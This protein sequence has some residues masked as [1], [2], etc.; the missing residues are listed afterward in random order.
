MLRLAMSRSGWFVFAL[1]LGLASTLAQA[2]DLAP[3]R[4]LYSMSLRSA[5]PSGGVAAAN[6]SMSYEFADTCD[7][8]TVENRMLLNIAYNEGNEVE[9]IWSFVTWESKDGSRYRFRTTM[10]RDGELAEDI[11]G[12]ARIGR[13][14]QGA[15]DF[16]K[17][18]PM[19]TRLPKGTMFPTSHT[20]WLLGRARANH[21]LVNRVVFDGSSM[22]GP[23]EV[24]AA[25]SGKVDS[26]K[27]SA[28]GASL[29]DANASW[30]MLLSFFPVN[31]R[32]ETPSFELRLRY[33]D[34]GI[35]D[36]L[37]QDFGNFSVDVRLDKLE[38]MP[39][40]PC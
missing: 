30:R 26:A 6:G 19:K 22:E 27:V 38:N 23:F 10:I 39:K 12:S 2:A 20:S 34:N 24:S 9:T 33:R 25:V 7:G 28:A 4:A 1:A 3:H 8:W 29:L 17:P 21:R 37:I 32:T 11:Q 5:N 35:T 18:Q 15:V 13:D 14:G 16:V 31:S 36:E 40:P